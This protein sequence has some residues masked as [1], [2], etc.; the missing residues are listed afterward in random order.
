M[1]RAEGAGRPPRIAPAPARSGRSRPPGSDTSDA[2]A[3]PGPVQAALD[4]GEVDEVEQELTDDDLRS[5][6][7]PVERARV[8]NAQRRL[9]D[10]ALVK[11][12]AAADFTGPVFDVAVTEFASYG[13]AVLMAWM[14]TGQI[15]GKCMAKGRPVSG[16]T[17][18]WSRDDR[19]EIAVET[20]A[21]ALKYFLGEV[22]APGKWDHSRG[23]TLKT[24][25]IGACLLQFP[26]EFDRWASEQRR[27]GQPEGEQALEYAVVR[28]DPQWADPTGDA[29]VRAC[30]VQE[31]L[32]EIPDRQTRQ[33]AWL[34][35]AYGAS[36]AEAGEVV[37]LS[38]DGVEGR[39]YRLRRGRPA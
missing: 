35:K 4:D 15:F 19:L 22:L 36:H 1:G 5:P 14:R 38:A 34:V 21:R 32:A 30:T 10:H 7:D 29:A 9:A 16:S 28:G 17:S 6:A 26:N 27:W 2:T 39:L 33:A 11:E 12:L 23:A 25:F 37:G 13:I 8:R 20:T 3:R 24:F 31:R 18:Q